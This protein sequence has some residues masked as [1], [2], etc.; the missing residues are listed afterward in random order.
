M[1]EIRES[2]VK[3]ERSKASI[4]A[5]LNTA[6]A[7]VRSVMDR[8]VALK[9]QAADA[10]QNGYHDGLKATDNLARI[11]Q[12]QAGMI[13]YFMGIITGSIKHQ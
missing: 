13:T 9:K 6:N 3:K 10:Y 5:D 2:A 8:N 11:N 1:G 7:E 12:T 4:Q